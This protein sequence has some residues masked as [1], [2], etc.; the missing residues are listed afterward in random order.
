MEDFCGSVGNDRISDMLFS[1]I[2]GRGAFRR[3]KDTVSK[4]NLDDSWYKFRYEAFK[5]I[6]VEWCEENDISYIET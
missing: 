3:F 2:K 4:Y 5:K 1:A 6:A